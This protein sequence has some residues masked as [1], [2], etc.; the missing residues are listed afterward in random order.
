M[1]RS[2]SRESARS[3]FPYLECVVLPLTERGWPQSIC[4]NDS[5]LEFGPDLLE[6]LE[7]LEKGRIEMNL[8]VIEDDLRAAAAIESSTGWRE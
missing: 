3:A 8:V 7:P 4:S 5:E 1:A 2:G 6:F